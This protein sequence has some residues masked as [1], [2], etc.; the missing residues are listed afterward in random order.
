MSNQKP[1]LEDLNLSADIIE[2]SKSLEK[3]FKV[4]DGNLINVTKEAVKSVLTEDQL[5]TLG[6]SQK[7]VKTLT[8]AASLALTHVGVEHM[9]KHKDV[10]QISFA[11]P[12]V[13]DRLA[14]TIDRVKVYE[15]KSPQ[16]GE[17]ESTTKHGVVTMQYTATGAVN[18]LGTMKKARVYANEYAAAVLA[19]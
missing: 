5:K 12:V 14:G 11:M 13:N 16:S 17:I 10:D 6:E 2:L 4:G 19:K 15:R 9:R 7:I 3:E 8:T 18:K 1:S